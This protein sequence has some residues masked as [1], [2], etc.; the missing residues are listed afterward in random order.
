VLV[1]IIILIPLL[2]TPTGILYTTYQRRKPGS[3]FTDDEHRNNFR[4]K[5]LLISLVMCGVAILII[6][7]MSRN[8]P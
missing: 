2:L 6:Y 7:L 4:F 1:F 5:M 3:K 8:N